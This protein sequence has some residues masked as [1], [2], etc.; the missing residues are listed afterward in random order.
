M[1]LELLHKG[2]E[3]LCVAVQAPEVGCL[4]LP[5]QRP[6]ILGLMVRQLDGMEKEDGPYALEGITDTD[7][8]GEFRLEGLWQG[9]R[10]PRLPG[11]SVAG[12]EG[13]NAR[14]PGGT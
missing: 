9:N 2:R 5:G 3:I 10:R 13:V 4:H 1:I 12:I 8:F 7:R 6:E 14:H 11:I